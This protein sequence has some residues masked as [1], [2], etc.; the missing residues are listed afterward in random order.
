[1]LGRLPEPLEL[2][3]GAREAGGEGV[4]DVVAWMELGL[5]AAIL[6]SLALAGAFQV[7][8][9]RTDLRRSHQALSQSLWGMLLAAVLLFAGFTAWVLAAGPSDLLGFSGVLAAPAARTG[10]WIAF[11]GPAARRPGYNPSF[12]Y[13]L[14][15]GRAVHARFGLI[16]QFNLLGRTDMPAGFSAD[17]RRAVWLEYEGPAFKSPVTAFRMDLDRPGSRPVR[18]TV[19]FRY[20]PPSFALSPDGRRIAAYEWEGRV[21][22][23]SVDDGRLLA[24]ARYDSAS[25]YPRMAFAGPGLVRIYEIHLPDL[26]PRQMVSTPAAIFGST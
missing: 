22:V 25:T 9:G 1:M 21:T 26:S 10:H 5:L 16:S 12:L 15:S 4:L 7:V 3:P 23:A 6:L 18:T 19:S 20:P 14:D 8:R 13:D 17:G 11:D 2:P 24:A